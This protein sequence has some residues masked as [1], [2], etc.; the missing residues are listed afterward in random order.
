MQGRHERISRVDTLKN[1][2]LHSDVTD[3]MV[4]G[5]VFGE[6]PP[7]LDLNVELS[8]MTRTRCRQVAR[9]LR[10]I[11]DNLEYRYR[12]LNPPANGQQHELLN[13]GETLL[14]IAR[15]ILPRHVMEYLGLNEWAVSFLFSFSVT[16]H[17][18]WRKNHTLSL[19]SYNFFQRRILPGY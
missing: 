4:T 9:E 11:G 13:I 15:F 16:S 1:G 17:N 18:W 3:I 7:D 5:E 10:K 12:R 19:L 2:Y 6:D 14:N 8:V